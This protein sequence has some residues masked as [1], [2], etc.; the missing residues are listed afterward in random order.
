MSKITNSAATGALV[1]LA[2]MLSAATALAA[3]VGQV[4]RLKG[5]ASI[6]LAG[7]GSRALSVGDA[8]EQSQVVHTG[9]DSEAV[10]RFADNA[11]MIV[12]PGTQIRITTYRYR[13][14]DP[15]N[16]SLIRLVRGGMRFITGLTG[17]LNHQSVRFD[18]PVAT[19]GIRGT[20]FDTVYREERADGLDAGSY[21][22]VTEGGTYM[23]D[24]AGK[25]VEIAQG[26]TGFMTSADFIAKGVA[27]AASIGVITPPPGL[28]RSG[29]FDGQVQELKDE[30]MRQMQNRVDQSVNANVPAELRSVIPAAGAVVSGAGEMLSGL[31]KK[32][33]KGAGSG[34]PCTG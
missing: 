5:T 23:R 18:T 1:L 9:P 11:L 6:E 3:G 12:R 27:A 26:Q 34:N 25:E 7:G 17:K 24:T 16:T 19:I 33:N 14:N 8:V 10:V 15:A 21:T 20:D 32:K 4:E 30:G 31:F 13:E 28:F 2:W 22:C 29:T